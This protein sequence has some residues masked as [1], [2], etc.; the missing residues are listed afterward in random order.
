MSLIS[1]REEAKARKKCEILDWQEENFASVE[2]VCKKFSITKRQFLYWKKRRREYQYRF[3]GYFDR[4]HMLSF[5]QKTKWFKN[6]EKGLNEKSFYKVFGEKIICKTPD[7]RER[8]KFLIDSMAKTKD[9]RFPVR[10]DQLPE[11]WWEQLEFRSIP[12]HMA[13]K[14]T[15]ELEIQI[16]DYKRRHRKKGCNKIAQHFISL[17]YKV[18]HTG[19]YGV[20]KRHDFFKKKRQNLKNIPTI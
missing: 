7:G 10:D 6:Y 1:D 11:P 8:K 4:K 12:N 16:I 5:L 3:S 19:V 18:G 14:I 9:Y 20:L 17:G 2:E 15:E 13:R